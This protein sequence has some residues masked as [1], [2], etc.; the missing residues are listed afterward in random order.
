MMRYVRYLLI[1][2]IIKKTVMVFMVM[3]LERV[4]EKINSVK[5]YVRNR[6]HAEIIG[7]FGSFARGAEKQAG[8][9]DILVEFNEDADLFDYV[10][11]SLY[12]EEQ[13]GKKVDIVPR[14]SIKKELKEQIIK[15]TIPL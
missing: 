14:D 12:L 5:K 1:S 7:I 15:E 11:L 6:Y 3:Y 8:D 9:I 4:I 13:L 2:V 10:G